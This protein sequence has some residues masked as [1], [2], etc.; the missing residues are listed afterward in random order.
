MPGLSTTPL[1]RN[2]P[3]D[4][5][6]ELPDNLQA[7]VT[8]STVTIHATHNGKTVSLRTE[9]RLMHVVIASAD[10]GDLSHTIAPQ[11]AS[12]GTYTM[13]HTFTRAGQYRIW[14]EIDDALAAQHHDQ[15]ADL[16]AY[17]EFSIGGTSQ[18]ALALE[19]WPNAKRGDIAVRFSPQKPKAGIMY[20]LRADVTKS[21]KPALFT[22]FTD[23]SN[24]ALVG[25]N[26]SSFRHGH[27]HLQPNAPRDHIELI[28]TFPTPGRY[29]LWMEMLLGDFAGASY[30]TIP[31][32]IIVE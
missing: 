26:F 28:H 22:Q 30:V 23:P 2:Q 29:V 13:M 25:E 6:I 24:Y 18:T 21:G 4:I 17:T 1:V 14:V 27:L 5:S 12:P 15:F 9:G 10:L 20:T 8:G 7:S 19:K 31:V 16:I 32:E 11:E 3:Y